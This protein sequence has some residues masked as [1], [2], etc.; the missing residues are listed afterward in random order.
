MARFGSVGTQ[1]FDDSGEVLTHG[2]ITFYAPGTTDKISTYADIDQTIENT[3]PIQLSASGRQP[4][5]FFTGSAKAVLSTSIGRQLDTQDPVGDTSSSPTSVMPWG[6][7]ISTTTAVDQSSVDIEW[8]G[9]EFSNYAVQ[10][11]G[12]VLSA[13]DNLR[14]RWKINGLYDSGNN[15]QYWTIGASAQNVNAIYLFTG[16]RRAISFVCT[17]SDV[18]SAAVKACTVD[19][20][21]ALANDNTL[22]STYDVK[23]TNSA[24]GEVRGLRFFCSSGA[25]ISGTFSLFGL[26]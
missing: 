12:G 22:G 18:N 3:N 4:S 5:I 7:L 8:L 17:I 10:L 15:Y 1:Y 13:A 14:A 11:S 21:V 19:R 6:E 25:N 16:L 20:L 24:T 9:Q 26:R 2:L 23:G